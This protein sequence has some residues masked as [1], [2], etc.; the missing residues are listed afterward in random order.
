MSGEGFNVATE[1]NANA[2]KTPAKTTQTDPNAFQ[3]IFLADAQPIDGLKVDWKKFDLNALAVQELLVVCRNERTIR[4]QRDAEI[5][6][7][8]IPTYAWH[9][10]RIRSH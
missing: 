6:G 9:L 3:P 4:S 8:Y 10:L 2:S 1:N 5:L 7:M